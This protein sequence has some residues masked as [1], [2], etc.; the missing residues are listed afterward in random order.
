MLIC[1]KCKCEY[2]EGFKKCS[3]CDCDLIE[4]LSEGKQDKIRNSK[5]TDENFKF[6]EEIF[7]ISVRDD[8]EAK[9]IE[10]KLNA[11]EVPTLK[12]YKGL[13]SYMS[14]YMGSTVFG[15]DIYVPTHLFDTAKDLISEFLE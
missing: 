13:G 14:V 5:A 1:P 11:Y 4:S 9:I 10:A 3:E 15:I 6:N 7:L 2:R 12:K 8:I